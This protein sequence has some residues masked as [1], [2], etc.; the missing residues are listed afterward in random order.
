MRL[1]PSVAITSVPSGGYDRCAC[2]VI[3]LAQAGFVCILLL[4]FS[5]GRLPHNCRQ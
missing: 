2:R 5:E 4:T 1:G 3:S